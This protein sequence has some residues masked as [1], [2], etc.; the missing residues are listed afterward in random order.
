MLKRNHEEIDE[1]DVRISK[2]MKYTEPIIKNIEYMKEIKNIYDS[3][4]CGN[5]SIND[6]NL[7][8]YIMKIDINNIDVNIYKKIVGDFWN[9]LSKKQIQAESDPSDFLQIIIHYVKIKQQ[10]GEDLRLQW[11]L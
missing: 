3:Y 7:I 5:I 10:Y 4:F 6:L 9:D 11:P 2:E 8:L 1:E